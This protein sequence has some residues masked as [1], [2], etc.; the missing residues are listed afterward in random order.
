ER[1]DLRGVVHNARTA[2]VTDFSLRYVDSSGAVAPDGA[3]AADVA[4]SWRRAGCDDRA[5]HLEVRFR[6]A[7]VAGRLR[8]A[9]I[10]GGHR[11]TPVWVSGPL[12]AG[13]GA[14]GLG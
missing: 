8:I 3:W 7:P 10:G 13:R 1:T 14:R 12:P 5:E 9:G 6:F 4:T 2:R 11:R